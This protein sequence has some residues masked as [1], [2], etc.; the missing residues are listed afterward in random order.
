MFFFYQLKFLFNY[1]LQSQPNPL[2]III[3]II[4]IKVNID[5]IVCRA[6]LQLASSPDYLTLILLISRG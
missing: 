4:W 5:F 2:I 3:G 6:Q 1:K